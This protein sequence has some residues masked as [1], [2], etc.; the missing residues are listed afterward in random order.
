MDNSRTFVRRLNK[1]AANLEKN[2]AKLRLDVAEEMLIEVV[3]AT[4]ADTGR[5]RS[6][7]MVGINAVPSSYISPYSPGRH[8]GTGESMNAGAAISLGRANLITA[9]SE[10][11]VYIANN[12][13]YI[14]RLNSG[15]SSQAPAN[16]IAKAFD[17]ARK[18]VQRANK[19]LE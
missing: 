4:P 10:D 8:L 1:R 9:K 19:L 15:Y 2:V 3:L 16:F 5:A 17:R 12:A 6:N 18:R 11:V 14:L 13:P 7:W